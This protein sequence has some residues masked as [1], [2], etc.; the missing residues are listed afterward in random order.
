MLIKRLQYIGIV[1]IP[2]AWVKSY[3]SKITFSI[4][5]DNHYSSTCKMYYGVP[6]GS[7]LWSLLFYLYI[8]PLKNI[9]SNFPFVKYQICADNIQLYIELQ[10]IVNS[11]Y[12]VFLID[13]INMVINWFLQNSLMLNMNITQLL[14][15]SRISP[16]FLLSSLI[17][18]Q[19]FLAI[20][21]K[22]L[23]LF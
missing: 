17:L 14:N 18:S 1:N 15:I 7:V 12:N 5:I 16:V 4:K 10:V 3:V 21:L 2:L 8:L 22:T 19:L 20:K 6:Q 23:V 11:S 9:I 13:C